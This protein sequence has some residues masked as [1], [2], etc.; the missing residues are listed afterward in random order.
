[1]AVD[2]VVINSNTAASSAQFLARSDLPFVLVAPTSVS[3]TE[4]RIE[5]AV[6]SGASASGD[7]FGP[8]QSQQQP[9]NLFAS[10]F[11]VFS[12]ASGAKPLYVGPLLMPTP[13]YRLVLSTSA[14]ITNT[15]QIVTARYSS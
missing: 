12:Q 4:L 6:S 10:P 11:T 9:G 14:S 7:A 3:A 2:F 15:F 1:M 5:C 13:F 8:I